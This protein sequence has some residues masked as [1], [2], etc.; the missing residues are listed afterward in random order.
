MDVLFSLDLLDVI[1]S[2]TSFFA[3][4]FLKGSLFT[5]KKKG[6]EGDGEPEHTLGLEENNGDMPSNLSLLLLFIY[7]FFTIGGL[8]EEN[9][10]YPK[11]F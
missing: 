2:S 4:S 1:F 10:F 7:L 5:L 6:R 9:T 3:A 8:S 11:F